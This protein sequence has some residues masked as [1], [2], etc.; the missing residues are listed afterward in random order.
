MPKLDSHLLATRLAPVVYMLAACAC[1]S[2][3]AGP[4]SVQE[5]AAMT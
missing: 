1:A 3:T 5:K 4:N 2:T